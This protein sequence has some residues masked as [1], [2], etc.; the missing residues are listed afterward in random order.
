V[1]GL[2]LMKKWIGGIAVVAAFFAGTFGILTF[3]G[4]EAEPQKPDTLAEKAPLQP[5]T[6]QS[7][8]IAPVSIALP[9][10]RQAMEQAAP[11]NLSGKPDINL[12]KFLS[13]G[14]VEYTMDRS[15]LTLTGRADGMTV[16]ASLNGSLRVTGQ[17]GTQLSSLESAVAGLLN[18]QFSSRSVKEAARDRGGR[19]LDQRADIKGNILVTARPAIT[20]GWRLEPNL[21]AQVNIAEANIQFAGVRLNAGRE[22]KPLVDRA[23]T[24]QAQAMQAKLRSDPFIEQ[25]ARREWGK[26][27]RSIPLEAGVGLPK[28]WLEM[29]PTRAFAAQPR[30]DANNLT[31]TLGLQANTRIV[32]QETKP[33]CPFPAKLELVPPLDQGKVAIGLPIDVPLREINAVLET[34]LKGKTFPDDKVSP[35]EV[36][37]H[38]AVVSANGERLL[39][40]MRVT[41]RER[42]SW[43]GLGTDATVHVSGRPQLDH[44]QQTLRL[45][46]VKFTVESE[47]AFGLMSSAAKAAIPYLQTALARNTVLDLK[48]ALANARRSIDKALADFRQQ[49]DGMKVDASITGLRLVGIEF[50]S[51]TMR[52]IAEAD[53][54]TRIAVSK[55]PTR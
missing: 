38:R 34:Q 20:T 11:R 40:S 14:D 28:L 17:L 42:K 49:G 5:A 10:I 37:V 55:L 29:R 39:V 16:G 46:D 35:A 22:L 6:R 47:A 23:V 7:V 54:I 8:I 33:D 53:G 43:F 51:K 24:E 13:K 18:N 2:S 48:P 30:V 19:T 9:T 45:D 12:G 31:L 32:P 26:L 36:T 25:A 1:G 21:Q 41:A 3:A 4:S 50:D 44:A 52:V 15:P 27:C